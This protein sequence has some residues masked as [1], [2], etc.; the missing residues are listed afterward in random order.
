MKSLNPAHQRQFA[1]HLESQYSPQLATHLDISSFLDPSLLSRNSQ[2][3]ETESDSLQSP[4]DPYNLD[5]LDNTLVESNEL[6]QS[7]VCMHSSLLSDDT[8]RTVASPPLASSED[9][10]VVSMDGTLEYRTSNE[11]SPDTTQ[12][13]PSS[14]FLM[15]HHNDTVLVTPSQDISSVAGDASNCILSNSSILSVAN[16]A[17]NNII[18]P[19]VTRPNR[20]RS[21]SRPRFSSSSN[22][23]ENIYPSRNRSASRPPRT[24]YRE[25]LN[26][27]PSR[28]N[29]MVLNVRGNSE[30]ST[31]KEDLVI[32]KS[33]K[34][35]EG[36]RPSL[37]A[38]RHE[39]T[40]NYFIKENKI[41]PSRKRSYSNG[42]YV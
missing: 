11:A 32:L 4:Q 17:S 3:F 28:I 7:P 22:S 8:D 40:R 30:E 37:G 31:R 34:S 35:Q 39:N 15:L 36:Y 5:D 10:S 6:S 1:S 27:M 9:F 23:V 33:V 21:S 16:P 25:R 29:K 26:T 41:N 12:P 20:R 14:H 13:S 42:F 18:I 24:E 2:L 38:D 19:P